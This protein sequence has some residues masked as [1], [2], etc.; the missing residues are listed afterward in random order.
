MHAWLK[1][2]QYYYLWTQWKVT[3]FKERNKDE[4]I[5]KSDRQI[6]LTNIKQQRKFRIDLSQDCLIRTTLILRLNYRDAS[7][8]T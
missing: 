8:V 6:K 3:K 5:H 1:L 7:I 4:N 2:F